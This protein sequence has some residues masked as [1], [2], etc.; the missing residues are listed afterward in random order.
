MNVS[1]RL[2]AIS[3]AISIDAQDASWVRVANSCACVSRLALPDSIPFRIA[4]TRLNALIR[5]TDSDIS[6]FFLCASCFCWVSYLHVSCKHDVVGRFLF[7]NVAVDGGFCEFH[8]LTPHHARRILRLRIS[9][10]LLLCASN[11]S[12]RTR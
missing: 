10:A 5:V 12:V 7:A 3:F 9:A 11:A 2:A 8:F 4:R 6:C 1:L